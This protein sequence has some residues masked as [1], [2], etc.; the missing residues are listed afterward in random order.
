MQECTPTMKFTLLSAVFLMLAFGF[1]GNVQAQGIADPPL[2]SCTH[3]LGSVIADYDSGVHG[4]PGDTRT[5]TGSDTVY[6]VDDEHVLQCFCPDNSNSGIQSNWWEVSHLSDDERDFFIRRGWVF[7]PNGGNW[8]L[9]NAPYLVKNDGF[10]CKSDG[11][12]SGGRSN[13][14]KKNS[15]G[16]GGVGEVLGVS[17]LAGTGNSATMLGSFGLSFVFGGL[18]YIV[19]RRR[20]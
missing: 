9:K 20:S 10:S 16:R 14:S 19:A 2:F 3:P 8:G 4:I 12:G 13:S 17:S 15:S 5:Y 18:A 1:A 11:G 7:I 6:N